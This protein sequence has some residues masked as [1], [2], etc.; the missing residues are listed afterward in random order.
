MLK[1]PLDARRVIGRK[2]LGGKLIEKHPSD[3]LTLQSCYT[4]CRSSTGLG[5]PAQALQYLMTSVK[6]KKAISPWPQPAVFV[7]L[8]SRHDRTRRF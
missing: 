4:V 2:G 1:Q 5:P 6:F 3:V 7:V 8:L